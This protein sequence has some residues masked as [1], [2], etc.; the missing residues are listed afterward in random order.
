MEASP[1]CILIKTVWIPRQVIDFYK[2]EELF[3]LGSLSGGVG[4]D[5]TD[6]HTP[7]MPRKS[8]R[9]EYV[10][11]LDPNRLRN[12]GKC[13]HLA[14]SFRSE[15]GLTLVGTWDKTGFLHPLAEKATN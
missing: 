13:Q 11:L 12:C 4:N 3:H 6:G 1:E 10:S 5:V 9:V 8:K 2:F 14:R 7:N 15:A